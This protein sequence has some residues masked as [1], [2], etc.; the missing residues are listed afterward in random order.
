MGNRSTCAAPHGVYTCKGKSRWC[1]IAVSTDREWEGFCRAIGA[2]GWCRSEQFT[3]LLGRLKNVDAL[4]RMVEEWTLQ[5]APEEVMALLQQEGVPAGVVQS[6]QD[7]DGDP[8]VRHRG[9]YWKL[10]NPEFGAFTYTGMP[11]K[12]SKTPYEMR[13]AP[14]LGEHNERFYT[15]MLG[16]SDEEFVAYMAE[17]VFE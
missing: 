3:T 1:T 14:R 15:Q 2:P 9:L 7:L 13:R 11:T 6:G 16:M 10:D 5:H 17:G 12:L 4:D 8:Q